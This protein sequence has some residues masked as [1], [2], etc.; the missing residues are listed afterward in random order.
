MYFE[1]ALGTVAALA[2]QGS[3]ISGSIEIIIAVPTP[4]ITELQ[5]SFGNRVY[6]ENDYRIISSFSFFDSE[7]VVLILITLKVLDQ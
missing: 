3:G 6:H 2:T 4:E 7:G 1:K 5:S